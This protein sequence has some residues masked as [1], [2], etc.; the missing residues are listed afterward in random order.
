LNQA[1]FLIKE[2]AKKLNSEG[3]N[4]MKILGICSTNVPKGKSA[5]MFLLCR[6]LEASKNKGAETEAV[7]LSD[8]RILPCSSLGECLMLKQCPLSKD[9]RDDM[10]KLF[11]KLEW[12]DGFIFSYHV[13]TVLPPNNLIDFFDRLS[14]SVNMTP[15]YHEYIKDKF[16]WVKGRYFVDKRAGIICCTS[17][18]GVDY[19]AADL[20]TLLMSMGA[21]LA[22]ISRIAMNDYGASPYLD[23]TQLYKNISGTDLAAWM[24]RNVGER[25]VTGPAFYDKTLRC[26]ETFETL[27]NT[28]T[29]IGITEDKPVGRLA[30]YLSLP[31]G[32]NSEDGT[33]RRKLFH[34]LQKPSLKTWFGKFQHS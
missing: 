26:G 18:L 20:A 28:E 2:K 23:E 33:K 14:T 31:T 29:N 19:G 21:R 9:K 11:Q 30:R 10:Q 4:V 12:A 17:G 16:P 24:A 27:L 15:K 5:S 8:Y 34:C 6:A 1:A 22:S 7:C 25:V 3:G 13:N 32:A